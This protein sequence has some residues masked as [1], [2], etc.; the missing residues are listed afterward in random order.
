MI[1]Y[2]INDVIPYYSNIDEDCWKE[3]GAQMIEYFYGN[4]SR[5]NTIKNIQSILRDHLEITKK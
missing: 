3:T 4:T 2:I 5:E 1:E